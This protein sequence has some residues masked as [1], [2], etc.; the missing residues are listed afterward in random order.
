MASSI[1]PVATIW[2]SAPRSSQGQN[3]TVGQ[4]K[5]S[6]VAT[7]S[8]TKKMTAKGKPNRNRILVAPQVPS[9]PVSDRC[10]ALRATCPSAA[11]MV[12]G[13]QSDATESM[14]GLFEAGVAAQCVRIFRRHCNLPCRLELV[15]ETNVMGAMLATA[16]SLMPTAKAATQP[17]AYCFRGAMH[18]ARISSGEN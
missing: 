16:T 1:K 11:M 9:G 7:S 14:G 5:R 13:I 15:N 4:G 3:E 12:K 2:L 17:P 6:P 8:T 18:K 10:I